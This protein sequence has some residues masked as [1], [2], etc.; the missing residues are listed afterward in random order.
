M[1]NGNIPSGWYEAKIVK[2]RPQRVYGIPS[3]MEVGLFLE[4]VEQGATYY[5]PAGTAGYF[6]R[7]NFC[8]F[9]DYPYHNKGRYDEKLLVDRYIRV[10]V[11]SHETGGK[12][13]VVI[14]EFAFSEKQLFATR[15]DA[16]SPENNNASPRPAA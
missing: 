15:H 12:R 1:I 2:V 3:G 8:Y 4:E 9:A 13:F 14:R 16:D 10:Y 11:Q 7:K 6:S 5:I